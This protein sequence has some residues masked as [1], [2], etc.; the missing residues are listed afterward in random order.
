MTQAELATVENSLST[1][2][3][4]QPTTIAVKEGKPWNFPLKLLILFIEALGRSSE[5][6]YVYLPLAGE[7]RNRADA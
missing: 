2:S 6:Y 7:P 3:K 4:T 1:S 5:D